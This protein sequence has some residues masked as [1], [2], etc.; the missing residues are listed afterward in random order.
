MH[1]DITPKTVNE[2]IKIL[3]YN[4]YFW[5]TDQNHQI[6]RHVKPH[7]KDLD[8]VK[9]LAEAQYA[10]TEKQGK[11]A[12]VILKRY[13]SKFEKYGMD[14]RKII[15]NPVYD[16]PFRVINFDKIIEKFVD[17]DD[18]PKIELKFPYHKKIIQLIRVL[19]DSRCLP[20]GYSSYDGENKNWTFLQT[21][22]TTYYLTM[23]AI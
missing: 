17:E 9:S 5:Y 6:K 11:L 16:A 21:D 19:K 23:F 18:Q 4:E 20:A 3:A 8:T 12:V 14:I 22:V 10:W 2:A 1:T 7:H 13:L 15:D